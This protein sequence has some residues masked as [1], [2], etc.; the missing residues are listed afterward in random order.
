VSRVR[1]ELPDTPIIPIPGPS[2]LTAALSVSG[3]SAAEFTFLGFLPHK[4]G[5]QKIFTE[6]NESSRPMVFY[7]SPHR[8]LKTLTELKKVLPETRSVIIFR[9]LTK[10]YEQIIRGT[11]EEVFS[12]FQNNPDH[13]RG[14]IVIIVDID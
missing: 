14:E 13:V 6:I 8:L 11:A 5:R 4:K 9:E 3:I 1:K 2:A 7:E 12:Y 10:I